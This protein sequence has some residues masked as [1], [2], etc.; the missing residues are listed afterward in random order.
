MQRIANIYGESRSG[1][2][3]GIRALLDSNGIDYAEIDVS[4]DASMLDLH[5]VSLA[6][7]E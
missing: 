7:A 4:D 1:L 6:E 3:P 2:A 5:A